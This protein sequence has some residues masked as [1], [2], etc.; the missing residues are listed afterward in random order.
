[1]TNGK[2]DTKKPKITLNIPIPQR[3]GAFESMLNIPNSRKP[4]LEHFVVID[5]YES[6]D[7]ESLYHYVN[8]RK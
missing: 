6:A 5:V 3:G 1:M 8:N 7:R 4:N 2:S